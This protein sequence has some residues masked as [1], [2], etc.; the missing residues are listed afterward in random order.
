MVSYYFFHMVEVA[1]SAVSRSKLQDL[2]PVY[3]Y[4]WELQSPEAVIIHHYYI[5]LRDG[6]EMREDRQTFGEY[7]ERLKSRVAELEKKLYEGRTEV[8]QMKAELEERRESDPEIN[9]L[10]KL[11]TVEKLKRTHDEVSSLC[12]SVL[13]VTLKIIKVK[14][15]HSLFINQ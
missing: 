13:L 2:L 1:N 10:M 8:H 9:K 7:I 4:S 11:E 3:F 14:T 15:M 5:L 6:S 12:A